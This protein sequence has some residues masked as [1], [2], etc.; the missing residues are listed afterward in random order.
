MF[1]TDSQVAGWALFGVAA[2][3][4]VWK[5]GVRRG[6]EKKPPKRPSKPRTRQRIVEKTEV[7]VERSD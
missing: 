7:R 5:A 6:K 4:L 1:I 2:V 3:A